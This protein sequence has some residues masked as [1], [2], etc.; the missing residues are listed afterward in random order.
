MSSSDLLSDFGNIAFN[1]MAVAHCDF[2]KYRLRECHIFC[3]TY[4]TDIMNLHLRMYRE[5]YYI[6]KVKMALSNPVYHITEYTIYIPVTVLH[7]M[8][9]ISHIFCYAGC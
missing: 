6:Q 8:S 1:H 9:H 2:H 5:D 7:N 3:N 4:L